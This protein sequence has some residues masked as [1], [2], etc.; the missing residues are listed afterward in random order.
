M[1]DVWLGVRGYRNWLKIFYVHWPTKNVPVT[2]Y[3]SKA[4][5]TVSASNFTEVFYNVKSTLEV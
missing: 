5:W 1:Y 2:N 4:N 3:K